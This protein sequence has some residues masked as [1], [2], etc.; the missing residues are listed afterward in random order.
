MTAASASGPG[1]DHTTDRFYNT[2]RHG[3]PGGARCCPH[4]A[5]PLAWCA[6]HP[7][8][9]FACSGGRSPASESRAC[10][11]AGRDELTTTPACCSSPSQPM[12]TTRSITL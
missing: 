10:W 3:V 4:T 8:L 2:A 9:L 6:L 1:L 7:R 5:G 11:D 12:A